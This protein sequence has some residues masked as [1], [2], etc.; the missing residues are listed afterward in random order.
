MIT[1]HQAK[2]YAYELTKRSPSDSI[3]K[4]KDNLIDNIEKKLNQTVSLETLFIIKW[5]VE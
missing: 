5:K 1:P 3:E 2:Y 4:Q